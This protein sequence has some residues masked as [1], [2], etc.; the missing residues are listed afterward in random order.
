MTS[1]LLGWGKNTAWTS[2][3][4]LTFGHVALTQDTVFFIVESVYMQR[5][6]CFVIFMYSKA[7][8]AAGVIAATIRHEL[9][10]TY[11]ELH[12]TK[13]PCSSM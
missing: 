3:H 6:E 9:F 11:C 2:K 8:C 13:P 7:C 5:L 1:Q 10:T 4:D 12:L